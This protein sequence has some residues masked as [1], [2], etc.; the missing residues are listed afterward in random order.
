MAGTGG[1]A[2][3]IRSRGSDNDRTSVGASV[4]CPIWSTLGLP[5]CSAVAVS[6]VEVV[7]AARPRAVGLYPDQD[8]GDREPTGS[9]GQFRT[10]LRGERP[11]Y[12]H[13]PDSGG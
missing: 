7:V 2:A 13:C 8:P 3:T 6:S 4:G 1:T 5:D 9:H 10:E 12:L 11:V